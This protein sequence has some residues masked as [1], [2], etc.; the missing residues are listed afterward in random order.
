MCGF[1]GIFEPLHPDR[2]YNSGEI[3][4]KMTDAISHRGPDADGHHVERGVL[5]GHRR[6][7]IIDIATGQQPLFNEDLTVSVVFNGEIYNYLELVAELETFGH[8][9][10]TRSDTEVIVHGWEQWGANCVKRFR[11]MFAFALFDRNRQEL[12]IARDR[13][14]VKPVYWGTASNGAVVFGSELKALL[15]YP[16]VSKSLNVQAIEQ[17]L[18]FGY[19]P[20]P[21]SIYKSIHK[22]ESGHYLL[23]KV[24]RNEPHISQYWDIDFSKTRD[25]TEADAIAEMDHLL[26]ESVKIRLMS[27]VP[28]GAFLSG[29]VDSSAVVAYM[30]Q[31]SNGPVKTCSIS[32]D[33]KGYDEGVYAAQVAQQFKSDHFTRTVTSNDLELVD[34]IVGLYDEPFADSSAMPT[35]R[36]CQLAR[37]RVTVALSGDGGDETFAG[38]RR[39]KF[40]LAEERL[41]S[42]APLSLRKPLFGFLS[43][44]Y[45]PAQQMP[46]FLRGKSTLKS[47]S[48]NTVEGYA[49]SVNFIR[50]PDRLKLYNS[51]MTRSLQGYSANSILAKYATQFSGDDP[52][53]LVQYLDYKTYLPGDINVKVDRASMAHSL[54]VREPLMDHL[55]IE[56]AARLPSNMKLKNGV[57][58]YILKKGLE[59]RLPNDIL[60]RAK[61]G[62]AIPLSGWMRNELKPSVLALS[63][64]SSLVNSGLFESSQIEKMA[65]EHLAGKSDRSMGLWTLLILEKFLASQS[66]VTV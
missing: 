29:G 9:F 61:M 17:Y 41:R 35:Y 55:L 53:S 66:D 52:L 34:Q 45:P 46:R 16:D 15:Q 36:V 56:W 24:G 23:W 59:N 14:G 1:A 60:Y 20:E 57:G 4:R 54:E 42:F 43:S 30:A 39:Y 37:E 31:H 38:Y 63:N 40:H 18:A 50:D 12:F 44:V 13:M 58:K 19:V 26:S 47:L 64:N 48:L 22:L 62:F 33:D 5:L 28:L 32:F 51:A 21:N 2:A 7:S 6:L 3:V 8:T 11:G 27:E 25:V 49:N 10:R 65:Q